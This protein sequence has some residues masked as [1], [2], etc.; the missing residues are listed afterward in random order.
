EVEQAP[1]PLNPGC[2]VAQCAEMQAALKPTALTGPLIDLGDGR[3]RGQAQRAAV[4]ALPVFAQHLLNARDRAPAEEVEQLGS[5]ERATEGEPQR[6]A[7]VRSRLF[8]VSA[9]TRNHGR[10]SDIPLRTNLPQLRRR[11]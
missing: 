4:S 9:R 1:Q 2:Q 10:H 7:A 8:S 11:E 6:N 3:S 5:G